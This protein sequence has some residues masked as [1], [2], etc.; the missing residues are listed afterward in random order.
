V[1]DRH[2]HR[3]H[4]RPLGGGPVGMYARPGID[5]RFVDS[6][7]AGPRGRGARRRRRHRGSTALAGRP[8]VGRAGRLHH[9]GRPLGGVDRGEPT[10]ARR[11]RR[12]RHRRAGGRQTT[13][14]RRGA[15]F[16][17]AP[18]GVHAPD[19]ARP[20]APVGRHRRRQRGDAR[21][22]LGRGRPGLR[23]GGPTAS[24]SFFSASTVRSNEQTRVSS[25]S[26]DS[27]RYASTRIVT[28][29]RSPSLVS[30]LSS[31]VDSARIVS[32]W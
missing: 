23:G 7:R 18:S 14:R 10:D 15:G 13:R 12:L 16:P 26:P 24:H 4:E 9:R 29:P 11:H 21:D 1:G 27:T 30:R 28:T 2:I 8:R 32:P 20:R 19:R 17:D 6:G 5:R 22:A 3:R 25:V 31:T